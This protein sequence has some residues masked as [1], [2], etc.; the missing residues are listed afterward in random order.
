[1]PRLK[2]RENKYPKMHD[3]MVKVGSTETTVT[4]QSQ[5][6]IRELF[7]PENTTSK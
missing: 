3:K 7:S 4:I 6:K 2:K 1:M 5:Q